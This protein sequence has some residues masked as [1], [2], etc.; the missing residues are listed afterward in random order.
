MY[1]H[2]YVRYTV[3]NYKNGMFSPK[4]TESERQREFSTAD[5]T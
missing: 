1:V 3:A 2:M 4:S 5:V